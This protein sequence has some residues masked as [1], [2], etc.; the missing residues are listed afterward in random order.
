MP[1]LPECIRIHTP[2]SWSSAT[3]K[4]WLPLPIVPSCTSTFRTCLS[5]RWVRGMSRWACHHAWASGVGSA[6]HFPRPAGTTPGMASTNGSSESGST[7]A[8][9]LVRAAIMP[10]PMSTPIAAG[11]TAPT[12][13]I[14]LPTVEPFPRWASGI[15]ATWPAMIGS[16]PSAS[17]CASVY[18]SRSDAQL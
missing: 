11:I 9:K 7:S 3:S 10:H 13:G 5:V 14:T 8:R 6:C 4:K 17:A 16:R 18:G 15:R 2:S 12:V 1:R